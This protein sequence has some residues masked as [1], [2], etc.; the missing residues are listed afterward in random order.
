M[1]TI[2]HILTDSGDELARRTIEQQ[3]TQPETQVKVVE[4]TQPE[5]DYGA[6]VDQIFAADSVEVW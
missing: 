2:L 6:V 4:L 3:R 5:P 1:R